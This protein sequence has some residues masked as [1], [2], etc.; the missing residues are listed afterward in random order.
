MIICMKS[1]HEP[2]K[3]NNKFQ[4]GTTLIEVLVAIFIVSILLS[5]VVALVVNAMKF[6]ERGENKLF[7]TSLAQQGLE[8]A[9]NVKYQSWEAFQAL[10]TSKDYCPI[11]LDNNWQLQECSGEQI[12][13]YQ[14]KIKI[15]RVFRNANN[16]IVTAET[17]GVFLDD[18]TREVQCLINWIHSN[19]PQEL[20][21][22]T[23]LSNWRV[24]IKHWN[25]S[26]GADYIY[27]GN[28]IE[29]V[30]GVAK[31]QEQLAEPITNGDFETGNLDDWQIES[32]NAWKISN[33]QPAHGTWLASS[34]AEGGATGKLRSSDF[35]YAGQQIRFSLKGFNENNYVRL[36]RSSDNHELKITKA[37]DKNEWEEIIWEVEDSKGTLVYLE[38]VDAV[39]D[40]GSPSEE[41]N[42]WLAID[43]FRQ[44]D[45]AGNMLAG[46]YA[47]DRPS[48]SPAIAQ[49]QEFT[50]LEGLQAETETVEGQIRYQITNE[51]NLENPTWYWWDNT[52]WLPAAGE[53]QNNSLSEVNAGL[54]L[55][56]DELGISSGHFSFRAIFISNG[57]QQNE[58]ASVILHYDGL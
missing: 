56:M 37:L 22:A 54:P 24:K 17:P 51:G 28:K 6:S 35:L 3:T 43:Y 38:A 32:G 12:E 57:E 7:A 19:T 53:E 34:K 2:M 55:F 10:D 41:D 13:K 20:S 48:I 31:L 36:L 47:Q 27:D 16:D 15:N 4:R 45:S 9:E 44:T 30:G 29:L 40:P 58:L 8:I 33:D 49:S 52:H 14:R 26:V 1:T 18:D 11:L 21:L 5:G 42:N 25:F 39:V 23:Y 46:G 50:S